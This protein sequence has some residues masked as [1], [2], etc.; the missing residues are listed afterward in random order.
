MTEERLEKIAKVLQQRQYTLGVVL[1]NVEDPHNIA[2]VLRTCDAAGV[3][4]VF[5]IDSDPKLKNTLG[6][7][8]SRSATKWM[9]VHHFNHVKDCVVVLKQRFDL[10]LT[11]HLSSNAVSVYESDL[12]RS[13]AIVFGNEKEGLSK[14]ILEHTDSNIIIPQY[15]MLQSLN[16]SVACAVTIFEAVRQRTTKGMY[17]SASMP[18][19]ILEALQT[20][21][22]SKRKS[23]GK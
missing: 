13:V 11:T 15:G 22:S 23:I 18:A 10:I 17:D 5:V 2:A 14:E 8:S 19:D 16:I 21:W 20:K 9:T 3:Q 1:E 4:D 7:R 6:W 12:T